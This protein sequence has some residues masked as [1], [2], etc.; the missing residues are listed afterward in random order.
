M[1]EQERK[2]MQERGLQLS[3]QLFYG[4]QDMDNI[5]TPAGYGH[6]P[7]WQKNQYKL[8]AKEMVN[9]AYSANPALLEMMQKH[10]E[11]KQKDPKVQAALARTQRLQSLLQ[12]NAQLIAKNKDLNAKHEALGARV[13]AEA[14]KRGYK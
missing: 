4:S 7:A 14:A 1:N 3:D 6:V 2:R 10:H 5:R 11:E 8:Q 13:E 12:T 9:K